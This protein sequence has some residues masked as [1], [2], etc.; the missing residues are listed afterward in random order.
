[1]LIFIF[2]QAFL[3]KYFC[4]NVFFFFFDVYVNLQPIVISENGQITTNGNVKTLSNSK[5]ED[6]ESRFLWKQSLHFV[7]IL[8]VPYTRLLNTLFLVI[9]MLNRICGTENHLLQYER[10]K[11]R[12]LESQVY[13]PNL[14]NKF[15][16][17]CAC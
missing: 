14:T 12:K 16:L 11:C 4:N 7:Q 2:T 17:C 5:A 1:M 8:V 15:K 13:A 9:C 6:R 10:D 3:H